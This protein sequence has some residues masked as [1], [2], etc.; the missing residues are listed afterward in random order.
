VTRLAKRIREARARGERTTFY[1]VFAGHG[2]TANG[3]GYLEF[4]GSRIDGDFIEREIID[5]IGSDTKHIL[6]DSC[7]S[8]FVINPRKPGGRRWATPKDLALSFV[9]RH[10][11]VGLFLSTNSD[12]EVFEWSEL[13]SGVFSHEVRSG[14][15]GAADA[16]QDGQVSYREL[17]GFIERANAKIPREALRPRLFFH[18]PGGD[19]NAALWKPRLSRGRRVDLA[20]EQMRLWIKNSTGERLV[21]VHKEPG[22]L[23]LVLPAAE[24]EELTAFVELPRA[25]GARA[26]VLEKTLAPS[27]A[28]ASLTADQGTAPKLAARG[29]RLFGDLFAD[30]FGPVALAQYEQSKRTEPEPVYGVRSEDVTRMRHYLTAMSEQGRFERNYFGAALAGLGSALAAGTVAGQFDEP[31]WS[32]ELSLGTGLGAATLLGTGLYLTLTKSAGE[33]ALETFERD[34]GSQGQSRDWAFART[35]QRL[36]ALARQERASKRLTFWSLQG[37]ALGVAGLN[38]WLLL[39][40]GDRAEGHLQPS[41]AAMGYSVAALTSASGF[42]LMSFESPSERLLRLYRYDPGLRLN[43]SVLPQPN[44][45]SLS[46]SGRF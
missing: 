36:E 22:S 27:E 3:R 33:R 40:S 46:L 11:E 7:N 37:L 25:T 13:E 24:D 14:M 45:V 26:V 21:D 31:R 5:R 19:R 8:F 28:A 16:N 38:T 44:G 43:V 39:D 4:E 41:M 2:D 9:E 30:P 23:S 17:A 42:L 15:S 35:E 29:A 20:Q 18:G 1:F 6:L 12:H 10:P 32:P 34:I